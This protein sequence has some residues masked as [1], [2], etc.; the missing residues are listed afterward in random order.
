MVAMVNGWQI[1]EGILAMS[2]SVLIRRDALRGLR[3]GLDFSLSSVLMAVPVCP[4]PRTLRAPNERK[5][6]Y[7]LIR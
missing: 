3:S 4:A 2:T 5:A 7:F 1:I 6:D